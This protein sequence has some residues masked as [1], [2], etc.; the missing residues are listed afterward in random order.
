VVFDAVIRAKLLR[1]FYFFSLF[2]LFLVVCIRTIIGYYVV[3]EAGCNWYL[4]FAILIYFLYQ[5]NGKCIFDLGCICS[6]Y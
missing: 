3:L 2:L 6:L 5:K 1:D 4:R